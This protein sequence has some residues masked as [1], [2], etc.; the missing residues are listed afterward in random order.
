LVEIFGNN[1]NIYWLVLFLSLCSLLYFK[2]L[3]VVAV[4]VI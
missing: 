1:S 4:C 2:I 3:N